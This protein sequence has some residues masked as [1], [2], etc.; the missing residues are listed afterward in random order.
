MSFRIS[1]LSPEPFRHLFGLPDAALQ[2]LGARRVTVDACPGFPERIAM[3]DAAPGERLLL[4][5]FAHVT[6]ASS[7][8]RASHAVFI[9][10]AAAEPYDRVDEVPEVLRRRLISLRAFDADDM[11]L[12]A[13]V[14]QGTELAPAIARFFA[15]PRTAY[16]HAHNA[17]PGCYAARVDRA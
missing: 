16:L 7:P 17:K 6:R 2:A 8:Y 13:D 5:N 12:D 11:M 15:D 1:G 9:S 14:M 10:E 3:R 4:V